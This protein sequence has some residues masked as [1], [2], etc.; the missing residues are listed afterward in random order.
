MPLTT[1]MTVELAA[2]SYTNLAELTLEWTAVCILRLGCSC[3]PGDCG[4]NASSNLATEPLWW[5]M[6][7][8]C[9]VN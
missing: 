8:L 5:A 4:Q 1:K 3:S 6:S 9:Q 2:T 7:D